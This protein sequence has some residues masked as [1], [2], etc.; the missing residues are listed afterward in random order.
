MIKSGTTDYEQLQLLTKKSNR[1]DSELQALI[2]SLLSSK[3]VLK[4]QIQNEFN[5]AI[6]ENKIVPRN[7]AVAKGENDEKELQKS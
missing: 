4:E 2:E 3:Y 5:F 1:Y 6:S 7:A